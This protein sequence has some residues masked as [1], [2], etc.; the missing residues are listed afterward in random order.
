MCPIT[1]VVP[2]RPDFSLGFLPVPRLIREVRA[3]VRTALVT[4]GRE[5]L[6]DNTLLLTSEVATNAVNAC[7]RSACTAPVTVY[8]KWMYGGALLVLVRDYAP[9][10][11]HERAWPVD[12]ES[13][14]GLAL[15]RACV[16]DW[17]VC[18]HGYGPGKAVWFR[19]AAQAAAR[20]EGAQ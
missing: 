7:R 14:R 3:A 1:T 13:G 17:G 9:G 20:V 2:I 18:R 6:V 4:A 5:E 15:V 10:A 12:G 16:T 19:V 8:A 11:P